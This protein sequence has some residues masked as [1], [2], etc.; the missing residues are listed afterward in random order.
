LALKAVENRWI[1]ITQNT[2][3]S[4]QQ[5]LHALT[6]VLDLTSFSFNGIYYE[7]IFGCS[8][9]SPLSPILADMV[10]DDLETHCLN[11]LDFTV[12]VY[13]RYVDDIFAIA[14]KSEIIEV[15]NVFNG[16]HQRLKFTHEIETNSSIH[17]LD[18]T[19]IKVE[20]ILLTNWYRKPTFSGRY[21]YFYSSHPFKYK[22]NTIKG[23]VDRAVLLSDDRFHDNN[24]KIIT[25]ILVNNCFP[26]PFIDSHI[27]KRIKTLKFRKDCTH[28]TDMGYKKFDTSSVLPLP[29]IKNLSENLIIALKKCGLEIIYTIP[30]RLNILI[31]KGKDRIDTNQ[32]TDVVYMIECNDCDATYTGQTK[33][34]LAT[35]V[36]EHCRDIK[37]HPSNHS[38]ISN[39][40]STYGH[41]FNWK[42]PKILHCEK[43]RK[44]RE[45]AEMFFIKKF[46]NNINLQKDTDNLNPIYDTLIHRV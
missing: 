38:V 9:G 39:H 28:N 20:G 27:C 5:F 19:V 42:E 44:K 4:L 33:R 35:R 45:I 37:K 12:P 11:L 16:Y 32:K 2:D 1:H 22:I 46:N 21:L 31:K 30:K 3:M 14:T 6:V 15:L 24:I 8:M 41:D 40:R 18:T 17:F 29:Y 13:Y 10:M 26:K 7:Q 43:H 36:N 25:D 34:Q 23:L